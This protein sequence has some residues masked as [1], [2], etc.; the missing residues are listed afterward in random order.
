MSDDSQLNDDDTERQKEIDAIVSA[1]WKRFPKRYARQLVQG[2]ENLV[3]L[4]TLTST[5]MRRL[6]NAF[7][8]KDLE[9]LREMRTK[10]ERAM[11]YLKKTMR[12][13]VIRKVELLSKRQTQS[14]A[15]IDPADKLGNDRLDR[16]TLVMLSEREL[17]SAGDRAILEM[18]D[19]RHLN[20]DEIFLQER[21][22]LVADRLSPEALRL[23]TPLFVQ[24]GVVGERAP[25]F[26]QAVEEALGLLKSFGHGLTDDAKKGLYRRYETSRQRLQQRLEKLVQEEFLD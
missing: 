5:S 8:S 20:Y 2:Q 9:K 23:L 22:P 26:V 19:D 4:E 13:V 24:P 16:L 15:E 6:V 14:L 18:R 10:L 7:Q 25:E 1:L 11:G 12:K 21:W 17:L 3:S